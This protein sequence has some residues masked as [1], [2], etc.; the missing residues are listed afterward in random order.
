MSCKVHPPVSDPGSSGPATP[1]VEALAWPRAHEE[2]T[3]QSSNS[4]EG[5]AAQIQRLQA[6]CERRA[7]Q[8]RQDGLRE[9]EALGRQKA[10]AEV[11]PVI[12]RLARSIEDIGSLRARLRREAEAD[13]VR[14]ALAIARRVLR[15]EL[16]VDPEALR[17]LALAALE[18]LQAG[19]I[20]R[21]RTHPSHVAAIQ[22]CLR[23]SSG[24]PIEV[25]AD[26]GRPPGNVLFETTRGDLDASVETQLSEIERGLADVLRR[27]S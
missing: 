19:E 22:G 17:G 23:Q 3:R 14:L 6:E 5:A 10:A 12:Q 7:A 21:V 18:K 27:S 24:A 25:V 16:A 11:E 9:G 15:R 8:S 4:P 2:T 1:A 26:A 13:L 20:R